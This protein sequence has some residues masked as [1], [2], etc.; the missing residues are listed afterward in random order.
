M[1]HYSKK[2][3]SSRNRVGHYT[4][5]YRDEGYLRPKFIASFLPPLPEN[6][7]LHPH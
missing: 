2:L 7:R 1:R 3:G 4:Y 6:A 5:G